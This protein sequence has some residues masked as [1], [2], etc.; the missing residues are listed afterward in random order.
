MPLA[1]I[2]EFY[3]AHT[4]HLRILHQVEQN[5]I[6]RRLLPILERSSPDTGATV[7]ANFSL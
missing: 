3:E 5:A 4:V 7:R 6:M 2:L 1:E